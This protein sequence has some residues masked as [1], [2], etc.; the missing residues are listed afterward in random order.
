MDGDVIRRLSITLSFHLLELPFCVKL[1]KR[2]GLNEGVGNVLSRA[3]YDLDLLGPALLSE[4][5]GGLLETDM[6]LAE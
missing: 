1:G 5:R 3:E 6:R 2:M 4:T